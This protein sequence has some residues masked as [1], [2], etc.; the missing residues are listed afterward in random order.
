M[1]FS[2]HQLMRSWDGP[3]PGQRA[4][5]GERC[6]G[7]NWLSWRGRTILLD[8]E[9]QCLLDRLLS[10]A[11]REQST[12]GRRPRPTRRPGTLDHPLSTIKTDTGTRSTKTTVA[13]PGTT[14]PCPYSMHAY[15]SRT[16][17]TQL[18]QPPLGTCVWSRLESGAAP[19]LLRSGCPSRVA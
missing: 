18:L 4:R 11:A 16:A 10:I 6:V 1:P 19:S 15:L 5:G 8:S 9:P 3:W 2:Q 17:T 7:R 14:R 12:R 13:P